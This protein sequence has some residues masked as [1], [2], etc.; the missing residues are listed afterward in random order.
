ML[1]WR[2]LAPIK[3]IFSSTHKIL[4]NVAGIKQVNTLLNFSEEK[5]EHSK[6]ININNLKSEIKFSRVTLRYNN[7]ENVAVVGLNMTIN[8]GSFVAIVGPNGS[9]KSTIIKLLMG[10]YT[11]QIGLITIDGFNIQQIDPIKLRQ[12]VAYVPDKPKLFYG[13]IAQNL[14]FSNPCATDEE[15][16]E[17]TLKAGIISDIEK[18]PHGFD[19]QIRDHSEFSISS[20]LQQGISLARAYLKKSPLYLLDEP[21]CL[22]DRARERCFIDTLKEIQ[23]VNK[24]TIIMTTHRPSHLKLASHIILMNKGNIVLQGP[25]NEVIDKIPEDLI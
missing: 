10:H 17:A 11:P 21:A 20:N 25:K 4:H 22:L 16:I 3:L 5:T 19:T 12:L 1:M 24:S 9:G 13:T 8:P 2:I 7:K 15:L 14:R 6:A 23:E 18:L